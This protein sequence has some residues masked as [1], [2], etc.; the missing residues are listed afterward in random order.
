MLMEGQVL[1]Q[2]EFS[3]VLNFG[4]AVCF[5]CNHGETMLE[6]IR[7][8]MARYEEHGMTPMYVL[9]NLSA[10]K[11][12]RVHTAQIN[13]VCHNSD[14]STVNGLPIIICDKVS[15]PTVTTSP[16]ELMAHGLV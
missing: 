15:T 14:E 10:Y 6:S 9:M 2:Q 3:K 11:K 1:Q 5:K 12:L 13:K 7:E 4:N 8:Q 16:S